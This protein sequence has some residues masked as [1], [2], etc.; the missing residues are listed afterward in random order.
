MDLGEE[1]AK[2]IIPDIVSRFDVISVTTNINVYDCAKLMAGKN[3]AAIVV[4][5]ADHQLI[6]IVTERDLT[7]RVLANGLDSE[8]TLIRDIMTAN[9][10]SLSPDDAAADAFELM[11]TKGYRHLPVTE[12]G[13]CVSIV[14]IRNL[15]EATKNSLEQDIIET[16]AFVFTE[17]YGE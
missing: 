8:K 1:M 10:D 6:G 3:I 13:K 12:N 15:Y 11:Q 17:R 2:K 9:P 14:S 4:I 5:D 7:Q 16:E